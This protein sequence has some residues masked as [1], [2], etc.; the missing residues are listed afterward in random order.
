MVLPNRRAKFPD[1]VMKAYC[2]Y[3]GVKLGGQD[4]PLFTNVCSK[5]CVE[6]LRD[7]RNYKRKRMLFVIAMVWREGKDHITDCYFSMINLKGINCKKKHRVP[8]PDALSVIRPIPHGSDI[9][10]LMQ[11]N[12]MG[13]RSDMAVVAGNDAYKSEEDDQLVL[14]TEVELNDLRPKLFKGVCSAARFTSQREPSV[15]ARNN[16]L[17]VS[18]P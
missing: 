7:W 14:L 17:L 15:G 6:N 9:P 16:V 3:F 12:N 2:N 1:F 10:V 4:K 8:Y 13:Y 5:T 18:R 11:D